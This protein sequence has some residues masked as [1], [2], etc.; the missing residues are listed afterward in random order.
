MDLKRINMAIITLTTDLGHKDFYQSALKGSILS[1]LPDV[2]MIDIT[3]EIPSFNIARTAFI[4]KNAYPYFPKNSVHLIGINSLFHE[5]SHYL[6]MKYKE[7]YFVGSDNGIFSLLLD[8]DKPQQL[9]ELNIIQDLRYLHFPLVDILCKAACH[10]ATGGTL[11]DIGLPIENTIERA[12]IQ[13]KIESN[14]ITGYVIYVDRFGNVITN[15]SKK[16]FNSVQKGRN[17]K[18]HFKRHEYID[19]LSW[20]YNEVPDGEKLCLFGVSDY[21]EIAINKGNASQLLGLTD[22]N[23]DPIIIDFY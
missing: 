20:N 21:L 3:H 19:K 5:G 22:S 9:V 23:Q 7:H 17:F 11:L 6:A 8:G 12:A 10:L 2:K 18:L 16:L 4:L 13:P 1:I 14:N 15:I